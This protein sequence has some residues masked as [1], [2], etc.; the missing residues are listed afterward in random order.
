MKCKINLTLV[1][2]AWSVFALIAN[3]G[4]MKCEQK[5]WGTAD[6][7]NIQLFTLTNANGLQMTLTNYGGIVTSLLVPDKA[8]KLGDVVLGYNDSVGSYVANTNFFGALIGRYGNRIGK[9]KFTLEGKTYTLNA[10]NG[11]N[12]LHGGPARLL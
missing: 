5:P 3:A 10:N 12:T 9:A 8:G 4:T 7:K 11:E 1:A 6:G 2:V